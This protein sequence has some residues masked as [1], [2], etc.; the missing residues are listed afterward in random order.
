MA[1]PRQVLAPTDPLSLPPLDPKFKSS[2]FCYMMDNK[3]SL[4]LPN[5]ST[6][7]VRKKRKERE[8][9]I[10]E[11]NDRKFRFSQVS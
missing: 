4:V 5:R 6:V 11:E 8:K 1:N 9:K 7:V 2:F 10:N 3:W